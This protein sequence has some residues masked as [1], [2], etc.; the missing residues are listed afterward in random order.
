MCTIVFCI[1]V[2]NCKKQKLAKEFCGGTKINLKEERASR[3]HTH[4]HTSL[5]PYSA[6][7]LRLL[8]IKHTHDVADDPKIAENSTTIAPPF[9]HTKTPSAVYCD[10]YLLERVKKR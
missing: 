5:G 1:R 6:Q 7:E 3:A 9:S 8:A 2:T 4:T 10:G